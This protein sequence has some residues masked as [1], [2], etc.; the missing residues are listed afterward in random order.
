[1]QLLIT[2]GP[3]ASRAISLGDEGVLRVGRGAECEVRLNDPAMSRGQFELKVAAGRVWLRDANSRFGTFVNGVKTAECELRP[4]DVIRAGETSFC[5]EA[6]LP[7]NRT[8]IAAVADW[9]T[10]T[11][12]VREANVPAVTPGTGD[13]SAWPAALS[14]LE[15][16]DYEVWKTQREYDLQHANDHLP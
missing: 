14:D 12:I 7:D 6:P 16:Y 1:M 15:G 4:G 13:W 11:I 5:V 2:S 10:V 3:D 8:T 9:R